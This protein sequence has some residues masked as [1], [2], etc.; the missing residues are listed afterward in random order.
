MQEVQ[1]EVVRFHLARK[2]A[3]AETE[4]AL[5]CSLWGNLLPRASWSPSRLPEA[6]AHYSW[7]L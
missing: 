6:T 1:G 7:L 2:G 3:E 5:L 4:G